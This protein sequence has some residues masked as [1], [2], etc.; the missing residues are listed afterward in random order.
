MKILFLLLSSLVLAHAAPPN[1][2][3]ILTDDQR[4]DSLPIYGNTFVKTPHIDEMAK[5]SVIFENASV[6]SAICTPSRACYFLGQYERKHGVN[7]NSGTAM[8]AEA[9]EKSYPVQLRKSG[10]FTGYVGKNHVPIGKEG[11]RT[12]IIDK[13]FDYWYAGHGHIKFYPKKHHDIFEHAQADTQIEVVHEGVKGFLGGTFIEGA[14]TFL[15]SRPADK[16]F[17]LSICLNVP[18]GAATST[19]KMHPTDPELYRTTYRDQKDQIPLPTNY[20]AKAD[21]KKPK[22]PKDVLYSEFMQNIYDYC[23]TPEELRERMLRQYQTITGIDLMVGGI[24]QQLEELGLAENTIIIFTSDHGLMLGE[25]GLKGKS[26]NYETCLSVPMIIHDPRLPEER[27]GQRSHALVQSIDVAPTIMTLAGL[28]PAKE[29]QGKDITNVIEGKTDYV[30]EF[31]FAENLWS[32]VFGNP[33]CESVRTDRY[34]YIRYFEN[35]RAP[36]VEKMKNKKKIYEVTPAMRTMYRDFLDA[37]IK[38]EKPVYEELYDLQSDPGELTN[39]AA[40]PEHANTLNM[41]RAQCQAM[42][43][44]ARGDFTKDPAV[45]PFKK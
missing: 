26:L 15:E 14:K 10:Y 37:T 45:V 28:A 43:T 23:D 18:H 39:L 32:N 19:M 27:N 16:P 24:R 35:S 38:G 2:I 20:V 42:V 17:C 21:L 5:E 7:F 1:I 6:T 3:F 36:W 40:A 41:L 25:E 12:G 22:L 34:K 30:R 11:Y 9:W 8:A 4:K 29:M 44:T 33:R 13:S 31:A